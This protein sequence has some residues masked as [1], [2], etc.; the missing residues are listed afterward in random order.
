MRSDGLKFLGLFIAA[1][2][3]LAWPARADD[4]TK[5]VVVDN[6]RTRIIFK[7]DPK[8]A[9]RLE[10][11]F[12]SGNR[13]IIRTRPPRDPYVYYYPENYYPYYPYDEDEH[14]GGPAYSAGHAV[15]TIISR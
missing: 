11:M 3:L 5:S 10:K 4:H 13:V 1:S 15:G 8:T 12:K 14:R 9:K 7:T 6:G 2:M